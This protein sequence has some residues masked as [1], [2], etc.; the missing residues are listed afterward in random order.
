ML[1]HSASAWSGQALS[2][3]PSAVARLDPRLRLVIVL[4]FALGVNLASLL[5]KL[6]ML[7]LALAC[8]YGAKIPP[9]KLL[10]RLLLIE[11]FMLFVL[12]FLPFSVPG[13]PMFTLGAL[14]ASIE[15]LWQAMHI[16]LNATAVVAMVLA[17]LASLSAFALAQTLAKL[18]APM[19]LVML[20]L[21]FVRYLEVMGTEL[22]RMRASMRARAFRPGSNR[23]TWRSYGHLVGMAVLRGMERAERVQMAMRCRGFRGEYLRNYPH[24]WR[25]LDTLVAVGMVIAMGGLLWL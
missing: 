23:H 2:D 1:V 18:G 17:M 4:G 16:I 19:M 6:L 24:V 11:G 20:M 12:V 5:A 14:S 13:E 22:R 7:C 9:R 10:R 21:F 25:Q 15:G 3:A 8:C